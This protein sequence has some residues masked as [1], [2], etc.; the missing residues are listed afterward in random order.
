[1]LRKLNNLA[2]VIGVFFTIVALILLINLLVSGRWDALS[3]YS[4]CAFIIF[5][6][7]MMIGS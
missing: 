5:G 4:A 7:A 2:F 3:L 1:M 6:I